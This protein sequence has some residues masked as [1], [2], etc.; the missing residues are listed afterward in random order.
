MLRRRDFLARAAATGI[1]DAISGPARAAVRA[2]MAR[3]VLGPLP[4]SKLG[5]TLPHEHIA[6]G[7]Y[8]LNKWRKGGRAA[9]TAEA[10]E[11]LK[12][13]RAA[14]IDTIVDLTTYDVGRDIRFLEEVSRKS[15]L[16]MIAATGQRFF[17]PRYPDVTM[18]SRTVEGLAA[19]FVKEIEQGIDGT[20]VKAGVI[21]IGVVAGRP[22]GLE[23]TGLRAAARAS[24]ATGLPIRIHTDAARRAGESDAVILEEEG[25]DPSR[26]SFDH[27]DGNGD[28]A[29]FLGLARRGYRLGMDHVHRGLAANAEPS[30]ERRAQNIKQLVDAGF[31]GKVFLSQDAEFGGS[32]LAEEAKDFRSKLD[33]QEGL[34]FTARTL[35]PRLRQIGVPDTEIRTMTVGNPRAFFA[36]S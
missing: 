15:G 35:I 22:T 2:G 7:P 1:A 25:M 12:Q 13:V 4:A 16:H 19:F 18:P 21:K 32:L 23:E 14:G 17:P 26:V 20:G 8:F 29:Y 11:K 33:P 27:S 24:K 9:F 34:L 3:T 31:A 30:F 5:Y 6:D 28:I 10:V 36:V